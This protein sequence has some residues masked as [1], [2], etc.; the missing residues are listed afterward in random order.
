MFD[1]A[2]NKTL[3]SKEPFWVRTDIPSDIVAPVVHTS[4]IRI[5]DFP[6]INP[7]SIAS[8]APFKFLYLSSFLNVF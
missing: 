8:K 7:L 4:S 1:F 5:N 6:S 3:T 2:T